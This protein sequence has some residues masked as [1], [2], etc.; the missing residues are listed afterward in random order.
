MKFDRI[1]LSTRSQQLLGGMKKKTGLTPNILARFAICLSLK[2][3]TIPNPEE[4][5]FEGAELAPRVLFG[6]HEPIYQALMI[7]RLKKDGYAITEDLLNEINQFDI[8]PDPEPWQ[9]TLKLPYHNYENFKI[10]R[11]LANL[12]K[13]ALKHWL[14]RV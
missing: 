10:C 4:Y 13:T 11:E 1:K 14:D 3:K 9:E 2:N 7:N 8:I 12:I 6:E 5:N